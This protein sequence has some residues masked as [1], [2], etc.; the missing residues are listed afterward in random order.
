MVRLS[1]RAEYGL[2]AIRHIAAKHGTDV[3]TAKEISTLYGISFDLLAKVMQK[4]TKAGLLCSTQGMHGGYVLSRP[5]EEIPVSAVIHAIEGTTP[6]ITQCIAEGL[7]SCT[8]ADVC[9]IRSPLS[10]V[11][12]NIEMAFDSLMLS[13]IV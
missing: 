11:Q 8:V 9:T 3:V 10:K 7:Q 2:I 4:M 13:Q 1:K 6:A 12:A 5:P